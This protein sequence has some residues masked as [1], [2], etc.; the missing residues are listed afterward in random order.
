MR[1][2]ERGYRFQGKHRRLSATV[3]AIAQCRII[4][5]YEAK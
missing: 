1:W 5:Y 2:R 4:P 3:V